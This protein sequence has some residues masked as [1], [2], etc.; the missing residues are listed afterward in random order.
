MAVYEIPLVSQPQTLS[1]QMP[2]GVT[3][4]LRLLW[5][6]SDEPCWSLD[7]SD[8]NDDAI[9]L[10][11]P[12]VTGADLLAQYGYLDFGSALYCAT[13]ADRLAVPTQTNLGVNSHLYIEM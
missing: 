6:Q 2:T 11:I 1:V 4:N 5:C 13:D 7:I 10:G 3:Y 8:A 12:L 9:A